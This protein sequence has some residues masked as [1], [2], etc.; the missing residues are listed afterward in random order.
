MSFASRRLVDASAQAGQRGFSAQQ[1]GG[2]GGAECD[3]HFR[4][5]DVDLPPEKLH[6]G[7][8]FYRLRRAV[9]RR[10]AF[11]DVRDVNLLALEAHGVDHVVE[12]LAGAAHEGQPLRV[13][14]GS[15]ALAYEHEAGVGV[16]V[17]KDDGV[18]ALKGKRTAG[19]VSNVGADG[20]KRGGASLRQAMMRWERQAGGG[21]AD[22]R[23]EW[24]APVRML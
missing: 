17:A 10:T 2:G 6:A 19:A 22:L 18:P 3:D 16:S 15:R 5:H 21:A 12:E 24:L 20:L 7:V 14:I 4:V 13:F 1:I 11:D 8:G 23:A 9:L